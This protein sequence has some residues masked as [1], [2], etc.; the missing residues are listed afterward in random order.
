VRDRFSVIGFT[1]AELGFIAAILL[2]AAFY[3][4]IPWNS[5][6]K[7]PPT[8]Q[9][10]LTP[11][12]AHAIPDVAKLKAQIAGLQG[13]VAK[14]ESELNRHRHLQ[15]VQK[16]SCIERG[17]ARTFIA[18]VQVFGDDDFEMQGESYDL[19]RLLSRLSQP[20][21]ESKDA[22]CVQSI[23]IA[24]GNGVATGDYIR[25]R[26]QLGQFFYPRDALD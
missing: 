7:P 20:L 16:P 11:H 19:T 6:P 14:L 24:P 4:K 21:Q 15:S 8:P 12:P 23:R 22:G 5:Q 18:D 10:A 13:D 9:T 17:I 1:E 3:S 26:N 25:G 2:L